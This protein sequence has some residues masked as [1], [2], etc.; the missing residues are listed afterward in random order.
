MAA[1]RGKDPKGIYSTLG[2]SCD[3]SDDE[4]RKAYRRLALRWHPDKN[5]DNPEATAEFQKISG[6]Y[7]V[8]SDQERREMYD[9]CGCIDA[10]D[11]D[12]E[13]GF[14]HAADLFSAFFGGGFSDEMDDDEQAMLD[15]FLRMSGGSFRTKSRPSRMKKGRGGKPVKTR[16]S[17]AGSSKASS[18]EE[19]LFGEVFLE[20]MTGGAGEMEFRAKCPKD[21]CL[22]KKKADGSYECDECS[23]DIA[24]GKRIYDCRK[25]D[26]SMCSKCHRAKEE[27]ALAAA[28]A[29]VEEEEIF[30]AFCEQYILPERKGRS[31]QF[32]CTL[33]NTSHKSE[34][35]AA[36]HMSQKHAEEIAE[37]LDQA[38]ENP[39]GMHGGLGMD[40]N[41]V[42]EF[43]M[44]GTMGGGMGPMGPMGGMM[45][46]MGYPGPG[47]GAGPGPSAPRRKGKKR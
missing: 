39:V 4:I 22:K 10:E 29:E 14:M 46:S 38:R 1:S 34:E 33:C 2:V 6:A 19:Q 7:E 42:L 11:L 25:C 26:Y 9:T 37:V 44:A 35:E 43:M 45:G 27:E 5:P 20:A 21:H 12:D 30:E 13:A 15:E 17:R 16:A 28:E 40:D 23:A 3:A 47:V 8:L 41:D 32:R 24:E 18:L 36:K 31:L